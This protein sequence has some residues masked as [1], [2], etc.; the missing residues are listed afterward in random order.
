MLGAA[1]LVRLLGLPE[2]QARERAAVLGASPRPAAARGVVEAV[3]LAVLHGRQTER[4]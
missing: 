2:D 1:R 4:V 3:R